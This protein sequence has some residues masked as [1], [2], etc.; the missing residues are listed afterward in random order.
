MKL[1]FICLS[2][3][4]ADPIT[5]DTIDRVERFA[6]HPEVEKVDVVSIY[7]STQVNADNIEIHEVSKKGRFKIIT[8]INFYRTIISI[9]R[10]SETRPVAYFYM[11]PGLLPVFL[12]IKLL[13]RI[14]TVIWFGHTQCNFRGRFGIRFCSD[15]WITSNHS[16]V[17]KGMG[18]KKPYFA[19]QGVDVSAFRPSGDEVE[20]DIITVGRITPSKKIHQMLEVIKICEEKLGAKYSLAICGDIYAGKDHAYKEE[21]IELAKHY[22]ICDRVHFLGSVDHSQLSNY[23]NKSNVFLFLAKGGIGKASLEA[24][25]CGLPA[26]LASPEAKDFF[27]DELSDQLLCDPELTKVAERLHRLLNMSQNEF[28]QLKRKVRSHIER[29]YSLIKFVDKVVELINKEE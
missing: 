6:A 21:A 28:I 7:G 3:D 22:G 1:L 11:T 13:F 5:A 15:K 27:P 17:P 14:E 9:L 26:V 2:V 10:K 4:K 18:G 16:M 24:M 25:A 19:G 20:W 8:L 29:E 23:L 12:P